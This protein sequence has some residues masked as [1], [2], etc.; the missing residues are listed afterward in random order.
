MSSNVLLLSCYELGHQPISLA[1]TAA[2]LREAGFDVTTFD[3]SVESF[4]LTEAAN[5]DFVGISSPMHT[6]MRLGVATVSRLRQVNPTAHICFFGLYAYLNSEYLLNPNGQ[7]VQNLADSVIAGEYE[8]PMVNLV[9]ALQKGDVVSSVDGIMTRDKTSTPIISRQDYPVPDRSTLPDIDHYAQFIKNDRAVAAGYV[10]SSRGC[11][12]LCRHC[13]VVPI[14][15]GRFRVVPLNMV[16]ADIRQQVHAGAR[17]ITFGDPDFLNGPGHAMKITRAMHAEFPHLSFDFTTKVE[18]ILENCEL[19]PELR[20]RGAAFVISAFEST[21]DQ[22][23][24]ALDKGHSVADLNDALNVLER[25]N[26]PVQPTWVPFNPWT[27]LD[28]YVNFLNWTR[29]RKL[30]ASIPPVQYSIRLL[31]PPKSKLLQEYRSSDWLGSLDP[32][33]FTYVWHHPDSRMDALHESVSVIV[34]KRREDPWGAFQAIEQ[35]AYDIAGR[36]MPIIEE[37]VIRHIMAPR[38]TE[39]WFC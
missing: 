24:E 35:A 10:E 20:N 30:I 18:H 12:H 17:H 36:E 13:P 3:L 8:T 26:L 9:N 19:L 33:N 31:L 29:E 4:P 34:E 5:A 15:N 32:E 39:D 7:G 2:F 37:P 11:L 22:V 25:A 6:A 38:L 1:L 21:S 27:S 14:Y 16:L 28:D 23:L